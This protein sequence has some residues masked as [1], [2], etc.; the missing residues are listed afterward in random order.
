MSVNRLLASLEEYL[1][2]KREVSDDI[3]LDELRSASDRVELA[4]KEYFQSYFDLALLEDR[5]KSSSITMK[6]PVIAPEQAVYSWNDVSALLDAL[7]NAPVPPNRLDD[8]EGMEHWVSVYR[9][10]FKAK[11]KINVNPIKK[12][13]EL[14]FE[15][16][17]R[18]E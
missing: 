9:E 13:L 2:M 14:D 12:E 3:E 1:A 17:K 15:E 11:R 10:W 6:V 16:L 8:K 18:N 4:L 5:R 7:N